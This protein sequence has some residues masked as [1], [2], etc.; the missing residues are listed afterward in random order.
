MYLWNVKVEVSSRPANSKLINVAHLMIPAQIFE[1][2]N[3]GLHM[4]PG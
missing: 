2:F 1:A 3:A 4:I